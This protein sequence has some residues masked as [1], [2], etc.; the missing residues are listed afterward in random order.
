[1]VWELVQSADDMGNRNEHPGNIF[2]FYIN[3]DN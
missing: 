3:S 1:M 2:P